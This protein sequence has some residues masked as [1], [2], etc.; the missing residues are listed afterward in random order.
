MSKLLSY[1]FSFFYFFLSVLIVI[2]HS[3]C[4]NTLGWTSNGS[5]FAVI[6]E[7]ITNVLTMLGHLAVPCF[8]IMSGFLFYRSVNDITDVYKKIKKRCKTLLVPYLLWNSIF[9]LL[10]YVILNSFLAQYIHMTNSLQNIK[11]VLYAIIN[12]SLTPLW[13]IKDLLIYVAI[14]PV[15]YIL[16]KRRI[17]LILTIIFNIVY[18]VYEKNIDYYNFLYWLPIYLIGVLMAKQKYKEWYM[19]MKKINNISWF[20]LLAIFIFLLITCMQFNILYFYRIIA[21]LLL[22]KISTNVLLYTNC[23]KRKYWKYSFFIY[24]THFFVLNIIQKIMYLGLG[25]SNSSYLF[26][27]LSS[28]FIVIPACIFIARYMQN[29]INKLYII[30]TGS[31]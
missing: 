19:D 4:K 7:H 14:S 27:Y 18:V 8:Y 30:L 23:E 22:W 5:T 3:N 28:P 21:P 10:F 15:I 26:I 17:L 29:H 24:C 9:V 2:L 1:K 16:F 13:F 20:L 31:R 6:I 25:T 12:S 11:D